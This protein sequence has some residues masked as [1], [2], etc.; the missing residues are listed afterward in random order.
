MQLLLK[1]LTASIFIVMKKPM[2]K[3]PKKLSVILT[4]LC[5]RHIEGAKLKVAEVHSA[6]LNRTLTAKE[7]AVQVVL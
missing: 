5:I 7:A 3:P 2:K 4:C 1:K 6:D